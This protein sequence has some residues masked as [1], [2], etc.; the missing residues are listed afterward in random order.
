MSQKPGS[1][2]QTEAARSSSC[3]NVSDGMVRQVTLILAKVEVESGVGIA[4]VWV[5]QV[6]AESG[7]GIG[8]GWARQ[9]AWEEGDGL[10]LAMGGEE[11]G[12]LRTVLPGRKSGSLFGA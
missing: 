11:R 8:A 12:R 7:I 2:P 4:A 9:G 10:G 6:G 3:S 1:I 5:R